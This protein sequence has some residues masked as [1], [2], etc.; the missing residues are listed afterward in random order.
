MHHTSRCRR[1]AG[2]VTAGVASLALAASSSA[3]LLSL[4]GDGSK[5]NDDPANGINPALEADGGDT[6]GGALGPGLQIPWTTFEQAAANGVLQV[7]VR[8]YRNG[9][10]VTQGSPASLNLDTG[11]EG[12]AP[13]I[14]F[15]G[16]NRNTPW[17]AW[18]EA[19]AHLPGGATNIFASRFENGA[20]LRSGQNR[21]TDGSQV[22]SLNVNTDRAAE[23]PQVIGG[24]TTAGNQP[25]PWIVWR[26]K[27]GA[28]SS[29]TRRFQIFVSRGVAQPGTCTGFTPG[30]GAALGDFCWQ[31]VGIPRV[32]RTSFA[33]AGA[34][35]PSLNVDV[36]RDANSP[37]GAFAGPDDTVPWI[38]WY[39]SGPSSAGLRA[40][41]QVFAARGEPDAAA[42]GGFRWVAVGAGTVGPG[43]TLDVSGTHN[44]SCAESLAAE[45]ACSLNKNPLANAVDARVAAGSLSPDTPTTPWVIWQEET[46]PG[47]NAIFVSSLVGEKFVLANNGQPI[48]NPANVA[49]LP[50][51]TFAGNV[52]YVS[53]ME[54]VG[55]TA[56]AFVGH[57]E[58]Q[59]FRLDTP[60][61]VPWGPLDIE[62]RPA[63]SST[64][65][66][67]P[68]N[69]D[70]RA[71]TGGAL[72]TAFITGVTIAEP[73]SLY[74]AAYA[75]TEVATG[76]ASS[77]DVLSAKVGFS[78]EPGG[79]AV[80]YHLDW[81]ETTAYGNEKPTSVLAA[82][83]AALNVTEDLTD[84]R[85][86]TEYHYR[87]AAATDFGRFL[88]QDRVFQT[89]ALEAAILTPK[90]KGIVRR[91]F[92]S[93]LVRGSVN[94][95]AHITIVLKKGRTTKARRTLKTDA[96]GI[97]SNRITLPRTL[98]GKLNLTVVINVNGTTKTLRRVFTRP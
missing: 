63:I 41:S 58:G 24:A 6:V 95:P 96:A 15:A 60:A 40:N 45:D 1:A 70:G 44:G 43:S 34:T 37:N 48:S 80:R 65:T 47:Q 83:S 76:R 67:V 16:L 12:A 55:T 20:W 91:K 28:N 84:L 21:A 42:L 82:R 72:G 94:A 90:P 19:S 29:A 98:R 92:K 79:T 75:P 36:T 49:A 85:P 22:A 54:N 78:I 53:W 93:V 66:A 11:E 81:G 77:V 27:D 68:A 17:V 89:A 2:I 88:G 9:A 38:V 97:W 73:T 57:F 33:G 46:G 69:Q 71:C 62:A 56:R 23:E 26:E 59:T 86:G 35:D 14:D 13:T 61:G 30:S 18:Y 74:A 87:V 51:I 52:P 5:V 64:C 50:D 8:A 32:S 10:W 4:P 3:S 7:V 39:E 25:D 31:S